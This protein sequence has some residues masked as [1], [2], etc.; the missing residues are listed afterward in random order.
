MRRDW[1]SL[2][3]TAKYLGISKPDL[4]RHRW[5]GTWVE[6]PV[7]ILVFPLCLRLCCVLC[8]CL[9]QLPLGFSDDMVCNGL[10][11]RAG[12]FLKDHFL[13]LWHCCIHQLRF[14]WHV[15]IL[16]VIDC[17]LHR[18]QRRHGALQ[19]QSLDHIFPLAEP[20]DKI[21]ALLH[22]F[23]DQSCLI[24]QLC[25]LIGPFLCVLF[26]LILLQ[27]CNLVFKG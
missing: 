2:P 7:L 23:L 3:L 9:G 26:L 5:I 16:V 17:L 24:V 15:L 20:Q 25:Q 6:A 10:L 11:L 13:N 27:N 12:H 1:L 21:I 22:A 4:S 18:S 8:H 19:L 14:G